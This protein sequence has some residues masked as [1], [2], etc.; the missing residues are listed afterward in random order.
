MAGSHEANIRE[1]SN[2]TRIAGPSIFLVLRYN[3]PE[4]QP[5]IKNTAKLSKKIIR[6]DGK[7]GVKRLKNASGFSRANI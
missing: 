5:S 6:G 2:A 1:M 7:S 4:T 3:H